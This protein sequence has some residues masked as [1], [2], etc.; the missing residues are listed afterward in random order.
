MN[1]FF[2][3]KELNQDFLIYIFF[4][5]RYL[6]QETYKNMINISVVYM[7]ET[8]SWGTDLFPGGQ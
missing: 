4:N 6:N 5:F 8:A 3:F 1:Y 2:N 7:T